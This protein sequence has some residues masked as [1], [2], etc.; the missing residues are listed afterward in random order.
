[1]NQQEGFSLKNDVSRNWI[2]SR[3]RMKRLQRESRSFAGSSI[4]GS[5]RE[6]LY[7]EAEGCG[8]HYVSYSQNDKLIAD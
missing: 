4:L 7:D 6:S 1:M 2:V 5:E 3:I 8:S